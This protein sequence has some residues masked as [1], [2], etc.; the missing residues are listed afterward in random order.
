MEDYFDINT[1]REIINLQYGYRTD[2]YSDEIVEKCKEHLTDSDL[3]LIS[4]KSLRRYI[5]KYIE[6]KFKETYGRHPFTDDERNKIIHKK[7]ATK[8]QRYNINDVLKMLEDNHVNNL[9]QNRKKE[10]TYEGKTIQG[11]VFAIP[12]FVKEYYNKMNTLNLE[13]N[14]EIE[15]YNE[16]K[17]YEDVELDKILQ[18]L[19]K[20]KQRRGN[21]LLKMYEKATEDINEMVQSERPLSK[22]ELKRQ[23]EIAEKF[24]KE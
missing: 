1:I 15:F 12:Y 7:G 16:I 13:T 23:M 22:K 2:I 21:L 10:K 6:R 17:E 4:S 5:D 9:I 3:Y 24:A 11:Y 8:G 18:V 19:Q 20:E 14:E